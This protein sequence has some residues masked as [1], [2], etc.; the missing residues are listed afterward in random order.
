MCKTFVKTEYEI[1]YRT[2]DGP[3]FTYWC[4]SFEE[5]RKELKKLKKYKFRVKNVYEYTTTKEEFDIA[6]YE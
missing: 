1:V 4:Y 6:K 3:E 2:S 5:V